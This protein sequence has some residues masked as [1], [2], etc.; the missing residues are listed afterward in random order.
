LP[1]SETLESIVTYTDLDGKVHK[2]IVPGDSLQTGVKGFDRLVPFF[3]ETRYIP[4]PD[5]LDTYVSDASKGVFPEVVPVSL[6][7]S[8]WGLELLSNDLPAQSGS[9]KL[10]SAWDGNPETYA[11]TLGVP[12]PHHFTIDLGVSEAIQLSEF[13]WAGFPP[14][15]KV[16]VKNYQVWG[17]ADI[18]NAET[19]KLITVD[20]LGWEAEM[21]SKGWVKLLE[22]TREQGDEEHASA[23]DHKAFVKFVR[24]VVIDS[25]SP[26]NP[27]IAWGEI[28][29]KGFLIF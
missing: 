4:E 6:N 21:E 8:L 13:S 23:I 14:F 17:I 11:A 18:T 12:G 15:S 27:D 1:L 22:N 9:F 24:I 26:Q 28:G 20:R 5:A 10:N 2:I 19:A 16:E 29:L 7:K 3:I 25:F